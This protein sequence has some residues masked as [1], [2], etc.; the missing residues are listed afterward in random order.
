[1]A[2]RGCRSRAKL[3]F[4]FSANHKTSP[5]VAAWRCVR[6]SLSRTVRRGQCVEGTSAISLV[7]SPVRCGGAELRSQRPIEGAET[8]HSCAAMRRDAAPVVRSY[9]RWSPTLFSTRLIVFRCSRFNHRDLSLDGQRKAS[10]DGMQ[11]LPNALSDA[12]TSLWQLEVV[13]PQPDGQ[14]SLSMGVCN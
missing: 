4:S 1:M 6:G 5:N 14:V 13:V 11:G 8:N 12:K 2:R 9:R 10:P 7:R 3:F